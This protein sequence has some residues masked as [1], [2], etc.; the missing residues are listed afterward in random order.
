MRPLGS[1]G[2]DLMNGIS[3]L[4]TLEEGP[5]RVP[6]PF[7]PCVDIMQRWLSVNRKQALTR[8]RSTSAL[9]LD[10]LAS[11]TVSNTFPLLRSQLVYAILL[12]KLKGTKED[13]LIFKGAN[14]LFQYFLLNE[15]F[16]CPTDI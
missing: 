1:E 13:K 5:Q 10:D 7:L 4:K 6:S 15:S 8:H 11:G 3:V 16:L 14:Q 12:Q 2:R 9:I